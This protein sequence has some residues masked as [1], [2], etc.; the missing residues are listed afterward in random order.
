MQAITTLIALLALAHSAL[1]GVYIT[2]PV[3][4]TVATGGQVLNVS[5]ADDGNTPTVA[6]VGPCTVD[7]YTGSMTQQTKL[8]NLA[9][10]VDVSKTSSISATIDPTVGQSGNYYFV[11]FT[12]L[13]LKDATNSAYYYEAFSAKFTINSMTGTFSASVLAELAAN[14]TTSS[15]TAASASKTSAVASASSSSKA[16]G[17]VAA[18]AAS[19]SKS[20]ALPQLAA[21]GLLAALV[22]IAGWI[23]L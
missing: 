17:S 10:S 9:A 2:S 22:G 11:R 6:S 4:G 21:P 23:A 19:T 16:S 3:A 14:S 20:A 13:G 15:T 1:A 7:L 18:A 8:Q 5:W 12:S